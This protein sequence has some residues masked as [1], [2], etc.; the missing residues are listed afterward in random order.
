M[1][2]ATALLAIL[3]TSCIPPLPDV[4]V[5]SGSE[6]G[7]P[8]DQAGSSDEETGGTSGEECDDTTEGEQ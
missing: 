7:E 2:T 1:K 3:L 6:T 4:P 8:C 5:L